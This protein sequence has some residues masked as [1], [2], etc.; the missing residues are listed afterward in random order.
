M[1]LDLSMG[2]FPL[3]WRNP[4]VGFHLVSKQVLLST[5]KPRGNCPS[6]SLEGCSHPWCFFGWLQ[7]GSAV[8]WA[9]LKLF[10][11][12]GDEGLGGLILRMKVQAHI[13]GRLMDTE[14]IPFSRLLHISLPIK[15]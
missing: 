15:G 2:M 7:T 9:V 11:C 13:F 4:S 12:C 1:L 10:V 6:S 3:I 8:F 14:N 5:P